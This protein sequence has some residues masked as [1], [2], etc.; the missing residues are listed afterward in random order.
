MSYNFIPLDEASQLLERILAQL[1]ITLS[2][3]R[4][5]IQGVDG[6]TLTDLYNIESGIKTQIDKL[7]FDGSNYL[8]VRIGAT[9]VSLGSA[10]AQLQVKNSSGVWTD[11]GYASGN[12][13]IPITIQTDNAGLATETTLS[14]IKSQTDKLAFDG[15]SRLYVN[16]A[17]VANPPNLDVAL[18]TR[19]S[20]ATLSSAKNILSAIRAQTDRLTFDALNHLYVKADQVGNP[21]NLDVALSTRASEATLSTFSS[22]F[23]AA[24]TLSDALSNPT[25]TI[26][27]SAVLG[28][29]GINWRRI[30]VDSSSRIRSV[31][32]SLPSLPSGTNIIGGVF[33]DHGVTTSIN[34]QVGTTVVT[35][36]SVDVTRRG[37][38]LIYMKNTQDV[39]VTITIE[40]S[41]DGTDWYVIRDNITIPAGQ[42]KIGVLSDPYGYIRAKAVASASPMSGTVL[43]TVE[44]IS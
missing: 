42:S 23:P 19:A 11:V 8:Y 37:K 10:T 4:D 43:V 15:S 16:A 33:S 5:A 28:W 44:S 17:V 35:G 12:L 14:D 13:S 29:D 3:L 9:D 38:K 20:E 22:K 40:G 21:P 7:T 39:D 6:R 24:V 31:V 32:E 1:D 27:G 34:Q 25:T 41:Y 36:S 18:S 2:S 30:A 26:V